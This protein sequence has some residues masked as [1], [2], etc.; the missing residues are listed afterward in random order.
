MYI[1][2]SDFDGTLSYNGISQ[3]NR[4][5]IQRFRAA[6]NLFGLVTGRD[7]WMYE[8]LVRE[9][10]EFDFIL[11]LN[12]AMAIKPDGTFLY[13]ERMPNK[14]NTVGQIAAY[15]GETY[16]TFLDC[17]TA[18]ERTTFAA[19]PSYIRSKSKPPIKL[20]EEAADIS[21]FTQLN[22]VFRS[23]D[24]ARDAAAQINLRWGDTVNALQ[25]G[26]CVDI[27]PAGVDKGQGL[28]RYAAMVGVPES[29]IYTIG[30]NMNDMAMITRFH[31]CAVANAR[32]EVKSAAEAVYEGVWAVLEYVLGK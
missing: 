9:N 29:N 28:A 12:G 1:A 5:A 4:D 2:A 25:N 6:G 31:G 26:I 11:A 30:D 16:H 7:F 27:P 32:E 10:I 15:L 18:R 19:D 22:T 3:K 14:N 17:L 24:D 20:P 8:T 23:D 13:C 21:E